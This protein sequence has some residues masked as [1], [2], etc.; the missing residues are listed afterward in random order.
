M[1]TESNAR[2]EHIRLSTFAYP[3]DEK[4][5]QSAKMICWRATSVNHQLFT[6]GF[7]LE[8]NS[9]LTELGGNVI[10]NKGPLWKTWRRSANVY[11][12]KGA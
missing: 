4:P 9:F 3:G 6:V 11:E 5:P 10:E 8:K 2:K 7:N 12:N 1:V